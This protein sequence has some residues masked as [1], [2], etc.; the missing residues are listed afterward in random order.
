MLQKANHL[1]RDHRSLGSATLFAIAAHG[2]AL[3]LDRGRAQRGD[4][5]IGDLVW[6]LDERKTIRDL[7][8]PDGAWIDAGLVHDGANEVSGTNVGLA[9][10]A[11][12]EPRD[13]PFRRDGLSLASAWLVRLTA[14]MRL[15]GRRALATDTLRR[16]VGP[17]RD[18]GNLLRLARAILG[19]GLLHR[20][21]GHVHDVELLRKRIDDDAKSLEIAGEDRLTQRR[22]RHLQPA[23]VQIG[24]GGHRRDLDLLF[25][26]IL[27][28]AQ[29]PVLAWL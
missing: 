4:D 7:N 1:L 16:S 21:G 26:L 25:G 2:N 6:Y 10:R 15:R 24:D 11:N 19:I 20:R 29:Q 22:T 8:R 13:V 28:V 3:P 5:L 9:S 18:D 23:R 27:D 14:V 17:H 12:V